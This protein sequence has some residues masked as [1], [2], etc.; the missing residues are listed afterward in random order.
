[1]FLIRAKSKDYKAKSTIPMIEVD[2]L[3][4]RLVVAYYNIK[5]SVFI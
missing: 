4:F 5:V 3:I 1:M 2:Q